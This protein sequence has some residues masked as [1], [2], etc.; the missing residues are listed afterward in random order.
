MNPLG[1]ITAF[2][3]KNLFT[4]KLVRENGELKYKPEPVPLVTEPAKAVVNRLKRGVG[5]LMGQRANAR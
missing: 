4:I 1:D 5:Q 2:L 3:S